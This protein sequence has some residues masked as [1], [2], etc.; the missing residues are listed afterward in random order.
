MGSICIL[1]TTL[2][3]AWDYIPISFSTLGMTRE[4]IPILFTTLRTPVK[5]HT[6]LLFPPNILLLYH[7][8]I[9]KVYK[10]IA[11]TFVV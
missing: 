7:I 10:N 4:N 6:S 3:I 11:K 1:F 5:K 9:Q 2:G 8:L